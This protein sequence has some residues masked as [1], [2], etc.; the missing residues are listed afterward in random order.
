MVLGIDLGSR[1]TRVFSLVAML[2]DTPHI[3][4]CLVPCVLPNT[5]VK[6]MCKISSTDAITHHT[7]MIL[8]SGRSYT[9]GVYEI[10]KELKNS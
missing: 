9:T 2:P 10:I 4:R 6:S 8:V 5:N 7:M 3:F 1:L